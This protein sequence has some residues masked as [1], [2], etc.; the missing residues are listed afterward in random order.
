M[1]SNEKIIEKLISYRNGFY[2]KYFNTIYE[3]KNDISVVNEK[4][5]PEG[6][7]ISDIALS[8]GKLLVATTISNEKKLYSF[9]P[10]LSIDFKA[11]LDIFGSNK[12]ESFSIYNAYS[13][14]RNEYKSIKIKLN[15]N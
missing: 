1:A 5:L 3:L 10:N 14:F 11:A 13:V 12:I 2:A 15:D 7:R 6:E 9:L 8:N 4:Q